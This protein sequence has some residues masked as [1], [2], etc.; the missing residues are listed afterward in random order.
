MSAN[1]NIFF[2]IHKKLL[3][4]FLFYFDLIP[5]FATR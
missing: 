1:V 3:K 2:A 4:N 5:K